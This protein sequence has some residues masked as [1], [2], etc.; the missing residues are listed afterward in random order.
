MNINRLRMLMIPLAL[1]VFIIVEEIF[2]NHIL[3]EADVWASLLVAVMLGQV[4]LRQDL[5]LFAFRA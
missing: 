2:A 1:L 3:N 4:Q 5:F